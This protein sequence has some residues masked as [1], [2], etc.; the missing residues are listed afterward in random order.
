MTNR[1]HGRHPGGSTEQTRERKPRIHGF[2]AGTTNPAKIPEKFTARTLNRKKKTPTKP[3]RPRR[4]QETP[5]TQ[6][7]AAMTKATTK[8]GKGTLTNRSGPAAREKHAHHET[9]YSTHETSGK[10][11]WPRR[12]KHEP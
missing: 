1:Y 12:T 7:G 3:K 4:T 10:A 8:K 6:P 11:W 9:Y 5:L 2:A